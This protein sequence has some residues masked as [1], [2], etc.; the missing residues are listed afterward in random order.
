MFSGIQ[1]ANIIKLATPISQAKCGT[2]SP[3][4]LWLWLWLC[5][6]GEC[7]SFVCFI[8]SCVCLSLCTSRSHSLSRSLP[9]CLS[10]TKIKPNLSQCSQTMGTN[11]MG[12]GTLTS[13]SYF[14]NAR[15]TQLGRVGRLCRLP[16]T[17]IACNWIFM[18]TKLAQLYIRALNACSQ[19]HSATRGCGS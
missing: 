3:L 7:D 10:H 18:A 19:Q 5:G 13:Y 16:L 4:R 14:A 8:V 12:A 6:Y 2:L 1:N 17:F 9:L 11:Y 15:D